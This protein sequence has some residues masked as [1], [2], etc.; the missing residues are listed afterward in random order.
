MIDWGT[1][2]ALAA[3]LP[4]GSS[5]VAVT[6]SL[7]IALA[8]MGRP[9]LTRAHPRRQEPR[10]QVGLGRLVSA[11]APA[12]GPGR[13]HWRPHQRLIKHGPSTPDAA[14]AAVKGAMEESA[15]LTMLLAEHTTFGREA[16]S[17]TPT[18]RPSTSS[19]ST[20]G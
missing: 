14:E 15:R 2:A 13:R 19:S 9:Q 20:T 7:P 16:Y 5:M 3:N 8:L 10:R 6:S 12:G 4:R 18:L 1:T 17:G 11:A